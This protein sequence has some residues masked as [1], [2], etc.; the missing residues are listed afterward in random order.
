MPQVRRIEQAGAASDREVQRA[1]GRGDH[2][3]HA[4]R[5]AGARAPRGARAGRGGAAGRLR[6]ADRRRRTAS[7]GS[8]AQRHRHGR[9]QLVHDEE[10]QVE[11][12]REQRP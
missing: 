4:H 1:A 6:G 12:Q 11:A 10:E 3:A 2:G 7:G 5:A 9:G 8:G